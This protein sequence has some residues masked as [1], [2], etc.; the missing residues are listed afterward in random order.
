M[1]LMLAVRRGHDRMAALVAGA[2]RPPQKQWG[3]RVGVSGAKRGERAEAPV[4][5][6][7]EALG[8]LW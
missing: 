3:H 8:R 6:W 5:D 1:E 7:E 2:R 4:L